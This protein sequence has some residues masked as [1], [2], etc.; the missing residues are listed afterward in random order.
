MFQKTTFEL[1]TPNSLGTS[2]NYFAFNF[3]CAEEPKDGKIKL[4]DSYHSCREGIMSSMRNRILEKT[5]KT[6]PADKTRLIFRWAASDRNRRDDMKVIDGWAKRSVAVMQA[7]DRL[8][9]WPLTRVYKIETEHDSWLR[10][11][12]FHSSR[13]WMKASYMISLYTLLVRMCKDERIDGFKDFD[14]LVKVVTK[15]SKSSSR[16]IM[17]HSYVTESVSYWKA[18]MLGYPELFRKRK[19]PYYWDT[20]RL[21]RSTSGSEGLQYLISGN[22]SYTEVRKALL[23]FKL[24][25]DSKKS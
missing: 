10:A 24:Q 13:R 16:L 4:I 11:Y 23:K 17:D 9:G 7:F 8:A 22:T 20:S 19:L 1:S 3:A 25:L 6:Q 15:A 5:G 21:D 14:G 18:I 2:S 12:Y